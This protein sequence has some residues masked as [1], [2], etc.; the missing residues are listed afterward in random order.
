M[1]TLRVF[2]ACARHGNFSR[3]ADELGI[4]PAAVSL[5][6]RNLEAELGQMLFRRNGPRIALTDSGRELGQRMTEVMSSARAAVVAC[7]SGKLTLRITVTPTLAHW[8]TLRLPQY[9]ALGAASGVKLDV[10][11]EVRASDQFD[12]AVRSGYGDWPDMRSIALLPVL[13][14]PM[15]SPNLAD[16]FDLRRPT[17]LQRLPLLPDVNWNAWFQLAGVLD[18]E[19]NL[20]PTVVRTQDMT[21]AAAVNGIGVALLSPLL[22]ADA[23]KQQRL[24]QPFKEVLVGPETYYVVHSAHD[25]RPQ[26]DRFVE[27]LCTTVSNEWPDRMGARQ[28]GSTV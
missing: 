23:L 16:R 1:E 26:V 22:F 15:L 4:T 14:T 25:D 7:R 3:A 28:S 27:W 10:S 19:L 18:P 12:I 24:L 5:R 8:L 17:D 13:G 9:H 6:I 2:E 11:P 21:A 20:M